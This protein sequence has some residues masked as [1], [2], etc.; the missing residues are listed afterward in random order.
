MDYVTIRG[1]L[2]DA[3]LRTYV[4]AVPTERDHDKFSFLKDIHS[5]ALINAEALRKLVKKFDKK[6]Q[7]SRLSLH[8]PIITIIISHPIC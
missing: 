8:P 6:V 3:A 7:H 5:T 4:L 1:A 2:P